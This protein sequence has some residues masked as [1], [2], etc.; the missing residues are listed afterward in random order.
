MSDVI[1]SFSFSKDGIDFSVN[2]VCYNEFAFFSDMYTMTD[3]H[4]GGV[5]VQNPNHHR[6]GY[7]YVIPEFSLAERTENL[8]AKGIANPCAAAYEAAQKALERDLNASD[9]GFRV[10]ASVEGI[11]L[12][13]DDHVGCSF[14][15][16]YDD[17]GLLIDIAQNVF[18][19]SVKEEAIS[20][21]KEKVKEILSK[22][23]VLKNIPLDTKE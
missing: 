14:D 13:N 12:L 8:R 23:E 22:N 3:T 5:T 7:K 16:S 18:E 19:E 15:Y 10:S 20:Q 21:A 17:E 6:G 4:Q 2:V 9:Y 1:E 11:D